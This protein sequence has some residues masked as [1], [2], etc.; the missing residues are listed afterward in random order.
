MGASIKI[1]KVLGIP[2][3]LHFSWFIIFIIFTFL[4]EG[5]FGRSKP[6]WSA[7]ERWLAALATSMLLFLSVLA[8]ELSHSLV[9]I[10]RGIPVTGITLFI[11]GGVSQLGREAHKPSS[12]FMVAVVGPLSSIALGLMFLGLSIGLEGLS[13][14]LSAI[15]G[16]LV[17]A[18]VVL[19]V[20]NMLPAFPMDGGRVLRATVW[21][22]TRNYW[23]A[24]RLATMGGQAIAFAMIAAGITF[25]VLNSDYVISGVWLVIIGIFLQSVASA[26]HR[27]S[28][29]QENLQGYTARDV[30]ATSLK[31][32]PGNVT[33]SQLVEGYI[34][35]MEVS[36]PQA[37]DFFMLAWAGKVQGVI[38]RELIGRVPQNKW[39]ET[40]ATSVMVPLDR[41]VSVG[42]E[43][44]AYSVMELM[45]QKAVKHVL[46]IKEG[47]PFGFIARDS[48]RH[49]P[50]VHAQSGA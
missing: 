22:I 50:R 40:W 36:D 20:F 21:G 2:V 38:T 26:S 45:E 13:Q 7:D 35:P 39:P 43:E 5:H 37:A 49:F 27:Q 1:G 17:S 8:H 28:R 23:R 3:S 14:H 34:R 9:A 31:V 16:I 30:M 24:T 48:L 41:A 19:A 6:L 29:L 25:A 15:A 11:F 10:R 47:V 32:A 44:D 46:V 12:E 18:N 42:P 4:L 33:L